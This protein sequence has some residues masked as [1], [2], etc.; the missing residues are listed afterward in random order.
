MKGHT[1]KHGKTW[2]Y[3]VDLGPDPATGKRRQK[4]KGGFALERDARNALNKVLVDLSGG[5]HVETSNMTVKSFLVDH[6]LPAK[7]ANV[8]PSTYASYRDA[9]EGRVV[10]RHR[11]STSR[12]ADAP[13]RLGPVRRAPRVRVARRPPR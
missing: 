7:K 2:R 13:P 4:T 10:P 5:S 1:A 12:R 11:R 6:W 3:V 9:L 8:R